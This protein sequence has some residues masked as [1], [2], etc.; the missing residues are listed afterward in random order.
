MDRKLSKSNKQNTKQR[1][2][3]RNKP[4]YNTNQKNNNKNAEII[5]KTVNRNKSV[6]CNNTMYVCNEKL[7]HRCGTGDLNKRRN[8]S[9]ERP[10][11]SPIT[12]TVNAV[13]PADLRPELLP[14]CQETRA[15]YPAG[16]RGIFQSK[17]CE[18]L[19]SWN[20]LINGIRVNA[21]LD[22]GSSVSVVSQ[23]FLR[24]NANALKRVPTLP[25]K[26]LNITTANFGK[27]PISQ[28]I[29]LTVS[30]ED[31]SINLSMFVVSKLAY[32]IILGLDSLQQID[33]IIK[34]NQQLL[35][36]K[37]NG[38]S[39]EFKLNTEAT[40]MD[41]GSQIK[42]TR[43]SYT[44]AKPE[45]KPASNTSYSQHEGLKGLMEEF[46]DI[47]SDR[48]SITTAYQHAI[49]LKEPEKF[50]RKVY[51]IPRK[52][53]NEVNAEIQ[54]MLDY[55]IIERADSNFLNPLVVVKKTTGD[56]RLCLD[57]RNLNNLVKKEF[58]CA[59][60][61]EQLFIKCEGAK[62]MTKLDLTSSFW[63]IPIRRQDRKY[64]A[65]LYE[66]KC[67]QHK[68]VP[69][70]L[71]TSLS[72]IVKCL[73]QALGPEVDPY[74]MI[75]VDDILVVS[76]SHEEHIQHLSKIFQKFRESNITLNES[77]CEFIK[78]N[79]RFLG[80]LISGEGIQTDPEKIKSITEFPTPRNHRNLRGFLGLTGY[81]RRFSKHYA[82]T[83][84]PLLGLLKKNTKWKWEELHEQAFINVKELFK[85]SL[86]LYHPVP[87]RK[88]VLYTDASDYAIGGVLYQINPKNELQ[89]IG[90]ANRTLKGAET[91]YCTSEKEILAV[92][93]SLTKFRYHLYGDHFTIHSDNQA[94]SYLLKC[95]FTNSRL[96]RWILA[97]QEY[98]FTIKYCKGSDNIIADALS[99]NVP[100]EIEEFHE[101]AENGPTIL[102]MQ[103]KAEPNVID[104]LRHIDEWQ[105]RDTKIRN[106]KERLGKEEDPG[107]K[108]YEN[109][110]HKLCQ[111][112]WKLLIPEAAVEPLVW[113]CHKSLAHASPL[114]CSE[115][116]KE[117]FHCNNLLRKCKSILK[118]CIDCQ[119]AK[120]PNLHTYVSMQNIIT[121]SIGK[122]IAIDFIGPFPRAS[123]NLKHVLVCVD[124][125]TKAIR[126]YAIPRPTT[127]SALNAII[128]KYIPQNGHV[129]RIL[130]DQGKQFQNKLWATTLAKHGVQ[131]VLTSIRRPQG[132]LAERIN[133]ELGN[134]F[135]IY[136]HEHHNRW[137]E[138][139]QFFEDS[140]NATFNE[141][142]G[143]APNELHLGKKPTRFWDRYV[144]IPP[145]QNLPIPVEC[146]NQIA[147]QR[148][149]RKGQIRADKF[150]SQHKLKTFKSGELI[151]LKTN[152]V[153]NLLEKKA[154]KFMRLF[155]GPYLLGR[156]VAKH[157]FLVMDLQNR[158]CIGKYHGANLRKL[159]Q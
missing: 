65:F 158:K 48:P 8:K 85:T 57:M 113:A 145:T 67:Y 108:I 133:R 40:E 124:V 7:Q 102:N 135:R 42:I 20:V 121:D 45:G 103:Y 50:I 35:L 140:I 44:L 29:L 43:P 55:N 159:Y 148:I 10:T 80:H 152:P 143:F 147:H 101:A 127:K 111:G 68:V 61:S 78:Q 98:T 136:C 87:G 105:F 59:P 134:K 53:K 64:T 91:R 56:I 16:K 2:I 125:F 4:S 149:V 12:A 144:N 54:K 49:K 58:D 1:I 138:Y 71:A 79:V 41:S 90:Y 72:A 32:D 84:V 129:E 110:V 88:Y 51:P 15:K 63:Q 39:Y 137:P 21:L 109:K 75:F 47:F 23:K 83:I 24:G 28:Q 92:V 76:K 26:Q 132:N 31:F 107:F 119:T 128:K 106:L 82:E 150:N 66:N 74:T 30:K 141:T 19:P 122:M 6:I 96:S 25:V 34:I 95:K 27:E 94:L 5:E 157:T 18:T 115:C 9:R 139:L 52:Y 154:A 73:E 11:I 37:H 89:V 118:K 13:F 36:C 100:E 116:L 126:L 69:F 17:G 86:H 93:Y 151:L 123:R 146:K 38:V 97:I 117:H 131:A 81:Y 22:T 60:T 46:Q 3:N 99:R 156:Q 142:I 70:G 33:A 62:Y 77:K 114:K 14:E 155:A 104:M 130:S 120:I 112:E 153:A